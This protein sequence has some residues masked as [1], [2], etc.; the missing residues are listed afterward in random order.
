MRKFLNL[1]AIW[2]LSLNLFAQ[3]QHV[4]G[5]KGEYPL[6]SNMTPEQ[7]IEHAIEEA[8]R[9]ALRQVTGEWIN[10]MEVLQSNDQ[11]Q[12]FSS[13]STF[14]TMGMLEKWQIIEKKIEQNEFGDL[15]AKVTLDAS[16]RKYKSSKDPEFIAFIEHLK[17]VYSTDEFLEFNITPHRDAYI[18]IFVFEDTEKAVMLYPNKQDRNRK[19]PAGKTVNFPCHM[20]MRITKNSTSPQEINHLVFVLTKQDIPFYGK[21]NFKTVNQWIANINPNQR[22]VKY[23][24]FTIRE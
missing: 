23:E 13:Y 6:L 12:I 14:E 2:I 9:E 5:I 16:V 20:R 19:F 10:S 22:F 8:K 15:I 1:L 21:V 4:K 18:K 11:W 3:T 24:E 7:A 17:P